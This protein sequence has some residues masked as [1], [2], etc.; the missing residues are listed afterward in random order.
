MHNPRVQGRGHTNLR[1][2]VPNPLPPIQTSEGR[3]KPPTALLFVLLLSACRAETGE[4]QFEGPP[5]FLPSYP[6]E[7]TGKFYEQ[8]SCLG[9]AWTVDA[10]DERF[11]FSSILYPNGD[12]SGETG[13]AYG[14]RI[15]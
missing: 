10:G 13:F 2:Q 5:P 12:C 14:E 1:G 7:I 6:G 3:M 9:N 15:P 4:G 11:A 8:P